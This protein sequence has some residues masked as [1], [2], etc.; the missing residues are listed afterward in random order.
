M[1][2]EPSQAR[3][4]SRHL[5]EADLESIPV[6]AYH[7]HMANC[8]KDVAEFC[9]ICLDAFN[10]EDELRVLPCGHVYHKLC[11]DRW[12]L[13]TYSGY[14]IHTNRC[15]VCKM[16]PKAAPSSTTSGSCS[17]STTSDASPSSSGHN[18]QSD[19]SKDSSRAAGQDGQNGGEEGAADDGADDSS[20]ELED[21]VEDDGESDQLRLLLMML[22]AGNN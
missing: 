19:R 3:Y 9:S 15:P 8:N 12:F 21:D 1:C 13:G 7:L 11:V 10:D 4:A 20:E 16:N 6:I 2:A 22:S 18:G 5:D 17:S 14:E